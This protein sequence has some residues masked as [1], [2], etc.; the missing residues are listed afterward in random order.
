MLVLRLLS[1]HVTSG[2]PLAS[3][4]YLQC[5]RSCT[6]M[7][8]YM[9]S[10]DCTVLAL[11]LSVDGCSNVMHAYMYMYIK[12]NWVKTS[13][14]ASSLRNKSRGAHKYTLWYVCEGCSAIY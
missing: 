1:A 6:C 9:F 13:L 8:T 4:V 12:F 3:P 7:L 14:G 10:M 2:E 5:T 11:A